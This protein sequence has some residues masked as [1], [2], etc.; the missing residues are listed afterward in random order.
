MLPCGNEDGAEVEE[1]GGIAL[2]MDDARVGSVEGDGKSGG[3]VSVEEGV[4]VNEILRRDVGKRD[5]LRAL[6]VIAAGEKPR[7]KEESKQS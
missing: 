4:S 7:S 6:R 1:G 5:G 3:S 2:N